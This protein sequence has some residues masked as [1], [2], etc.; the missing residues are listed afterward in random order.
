MTHHP[1]PLLTLRSLCRGLP[2]ALVLAGTLIGG[3]PVQAQCVPDR[4]GNNICPPPGGK[5]L[6]DRTGDIVCSPQDGGI[7]LNRYN[8]LV[9]GAGAC[10][11]NQR[12]EVMCSTVAR[13]SAALDRYSE[14]VCTSG[15]APASA[16]LCQRPR[17]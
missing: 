1:D 6:A 14:A 8:E 16:A 2:A 13:G 17:R 4:Y 12:G 10:V 15:C 5:C 9:C 7:V 3:T 11:V